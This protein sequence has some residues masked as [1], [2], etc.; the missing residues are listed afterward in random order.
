M[1]KRRG[2]T[3]TDI[4]P[5]IETGQ[6]KGLWL[7]A[8]N[9]M[10]SMPNTSRIR[11]TLEKL[12]CLIVQD[13]YQ[14]VETTEYAHV[15]FPA[16]T[17]AEKEGCFTNTERRVNI[18][19]KVTEEF[20]NSRS[21]LWIFNQMAKRFKQGE[22]LR[23]PEAPAEVFG[24]M[25]HLSKGRLLDISGM[26]HDEIER[27][28]GIQWPYAADHQ[29][30]KGAQRLYQ[31]GRF[32]YADERAKLIPLPFI[33][34]NEVPDEDYPFWLNSGRVVEHFHTRTK[35]GKIGNQNKFSPTPYMEM[36]PDAAAELNVAHG[37]YV[38]VVSRRSDAVVMVQLT[39]R[40]PRNMVFI[41]FHYHDCV[42]RL[43]LG[44]LDPHSRQPAFKQNA[45]RIEAIDQ[46]EAAR[47][48]GEM[49]EF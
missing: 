34:N 31:D 4:F 24:E 23:F 7:V 12:E 14:D 35:T 47:L 30:D 43:S 2:L 29:D 17:W 19:R 10:T 20:G 21:D 45:V 5:A 1:P 44:L 22:R 9:P 6:I 27:Q 38:R 48:N 41:P 3:E 36:N 40:V 11:K 25:R 16:A 42:N 33:D 15:Y 49:R 32:Q 46:V 28:R 13:S 26:D 37:S 18:V 8:T 39:Q